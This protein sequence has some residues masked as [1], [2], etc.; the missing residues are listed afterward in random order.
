M[1]FP[2]FRWSTRIC[3]SSTWLRVQRITVRWDA[4]SAVSQNWWKLK[5]GILW[6]F[7]TTAFCWERDCVSVMKI[8]DEE[9]IE[10]LLYVKTKCIVFVI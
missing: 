6:M 9:L 5:S 2:S 1:D 7:V 10:N 3:P 8:C 4:R